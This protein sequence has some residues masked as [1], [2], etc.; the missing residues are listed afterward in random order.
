MGFSHFTKEKKKKK[1][2][3]SIANTSSV[4]WQGI[5][6]LGEALLSWYQKFVVQLR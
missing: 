4:P 5:W 3:T 1:L 2:A 6:R